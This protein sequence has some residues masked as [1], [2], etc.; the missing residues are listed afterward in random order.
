MAGSSQLKIA[1]EPDEAAA[2]SER[3]LDPANWT[4][5]RDLAHQ[6]LDRAIDFVA[7]A[8]ERPVWQPV[9]DRVKEALAAPLPLAPQGTEAVLD[10]FGELI[11]PYT[12]GN[13]HPRFFGWVHGTGT[14]SGILTEMLAA[15]IN[16]NVGG[17]EQ[18]PVYVER[19]VID[20]CRQ[21]FGMPDGTS[22]LLVSGTSMA[23][24]IA[25]T[26]ARNEAAKKI[27]GQ[28][29]IDLRTG[30]VQALGRQLVAYTSSEAH[31]SVA[32]ALEMIGVGSANLRLIA[33]DQDFRMNPEA[34]AEAI[35]GDRVKGHVPFCV[36][37]T[38]G[39]VNSGAIDPIGAIAD[40]CAG[41]GIWMH[42]DG[43]F[44]ALGVLS[45]TIKPQL[46]G[47]DRADSLAFDFH[48]WLHVPY[49]AGCVL[50][51]HEGAQRNAFS[52]RPD[53]L[54]AGER[55]LAA[56]NPWL[57]EFGPELSRSF[58]ALKVWFTLKEHGLAA[59]GAQIDQNCAQARY[60]AGK[61]T[62]SADL[63]LLAPVSL[64]IVCF[65]AVIDGFSGAELDRFNADIVTH[66]Q[67]RGIAAPSTTRIDGALA[68][69]VCLTNH[70]TRRDDIGIMLDAI[71]EHVL[72]KKHELAE[73]ARRAQ[74]ATQP[75]PAG[76]EA[77]AEA[78][79]VAEEPT[80]PI[81]KRRRTLNSEAANKR[82]KTILARPE[83][84]PL[85]QNITIVP[86][87]VLAV[88]FQVE[89]AGLIHIAS[90]SLWR[91]ETGTVL[92]RHA[93]ELATWQAATRG[94]AGPD[95]TAAVAILATRSAARYLAMLPQ[96]Q[97]RAASQEMP[98]WLLA[99]YDNL[100]RDEPGS[101]LR[102]FLEPG[103]AVL[104]RLMGLQKLSAS[105][106][107]AIKTSTAVKVAA[108]NIAKRMSELAAPAEV[109][110]T[111]GGDSRIAPLP[112]T[113][114]NAYH[115][116]ATP[117][118]S[119]ISFSSSTVSTI[120]DGAY[121]V[122]EGLRQAL[123]HEASGDGFERI[124]A[125]RMHAVRSEILRITGAKGVPGTAVILT[126][127]GTDTALSALH[128]ALSGQE[129]GSEKPLVAIVIDPN[130][131]GS[132]V[133]LAAEGRHFLSL[134]S[135][136]ALVEAGGTIAGF[137]PGTVELCA[138]R[139]RNPDGTVRS[140]REISREV[141]DIA[142]AAIGEGSRCLLHVLDSSKTGLGAPSIDCVLSLAKLHEG[143]FD[144]VVDACQ[145]RLGTDAMRAYLEHGFMLQV[146]GSK[147][148]TGPSF[149]GALIVPDDLVQRARGRDWP[150]G[151]SDY[152]GV[153]EWPPK[154]AAACGV[155]ATRRNT[156][157]LLRWSA[158]LHEMRAFRKAPDREA[159]DILRAFAKSIHALMRE[160]PEVE[161]MPT[162]P[163]RRD[164]LG[165]EDP[166]RSI[167]TIFPFAV[168]KTE[169]D[170]RTRALSFNQL[171]AVH[172]LLAEDI[173]DRLPDSALLEDRVAR[174][175]C[176]L[177]QPVRIGGD[178][179]RIGGVLRLC[180]SARI[181]TGAYQAQLARKAAGGTA[182]AAEALAEF[183]D[184]ARTV[185]DKLALIMRH[186]DQLNG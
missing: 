179:A 113:G 168:L 11:L 21:I 53:Y 153:A 27:S 46:A 181:V 45:E 106:L 123:I 101:G 125:A 164:A 61:V 49:D 35:A 146:T 96:A 152:V 79:A 175:R 159:E 143:K 68:I 55:G 108:C 43:A 47:I 132:G 148:F 138:V 162:V 90:D 115:S 122:A 25:L 72:D 150:A 156:G 31:G 178:G 165:I 94:Q 51:R 20:W 185:L 91:L 95:W 48:K 120:S 155:E 33:A 12:C 124:F 30:G 107:G 103:N 54:A 10:E 118:S 83:F 78:E 100:G 126:A 9:P 2:V 42:V 104:T 4:A 57:C 182:P 3:S 166:W 18:S 71:H 144:V 74:P 172:R 134:T 77:E 76:A 89:S 157:L 56:G 93:L 141:E 87:A 52:Q 8:G 97:R 50:I 121:A 84:Q 59:F 19:Q 133:P 119:E 174:T 23:T 183:V 149:S 167:P 116:S 98:E 29:A 34:L 110:L 173:R 65:R 1:S 171:K 60:L 62:Q 92:V 184:E 63:K 109:L 186:F 142:D 112:E 37:A 6:T 114:R 15:A 64:N 66:L 67:E 105:T 117:C 158:A 36:V 73:E 44:G 128:F 147:F 69:R 26:A 130:E 137:E 32:K 111:S 16:A 127:S 75:A 163:L 14:A 41:H 131:T 102:E 24:L 170:G 13:T 161:L 80:P 145:M 135:Q 5:F 86:S 139:L 81:T 99:A 28:D 180:S 39:T 154:L 58:R 82:L 70:R 136:G 85:V 176:L 140:P 169:S 177:G 151:L 88:P 22:G 38:A 40:V 129:A 7:T 160:R 17:R